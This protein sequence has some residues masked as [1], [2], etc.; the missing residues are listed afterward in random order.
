MT[1][2]YF[3]I[4]LSVIIC[5]HEAGHL[6]TAKMFGVYCYEYAFGMGPTLFKKQ[7]K[8][9]VYSIHAIPIGGFVAMAG[10]TEGDEVYPDVVVPEGRRINDI[11]PWKRIIVM[12]AGVFM[13]FMLAWVIFS[14]IYLSIGAYGRS[15]KPYVESVMENTPAERAGFESGDLVV[16]ISLNDGTSVKPKDF[17]DMQ[18]FLAQYADQELIYVVERNGQNVS[19]P[20][21]PE[22]N[23]E[24][25]SYM[26]G[27]I[28]PD[29][30]IEEV[31]LLNCWRYGAEEMSSIAGL[32]VRTLRQLIRGKGLNQLAGPVG[33]YNATAEY[34]S[35]GFLSFMFLMA[36]LSLNVGI[37][38]L[39]PLPVL[40][41]GQVVLVL[42]EK[43]IG[44]PL[45]HKL[46]AA[47]MGV[48]WVIL[49]SI[50]VFVT[51]NDISR[52]FR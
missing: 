2:I 9:T 16:S 28:G 48:F 1:I 38:N 31:N 23:E 44:K 15:P 24:R 47:I 34:A 35:L 17:T 5:I 46:K 41:G 22:Y 6:I 3:L 42:A 25:D 4:L 8:E 20:V 26:I 12:L 21:T 14:M 33:I 27:I 45:N 37:M 52:L 43:V 18:M 40:D 29:L 30:E 13:N 49:I 7:G 11:K 10:E 19:I 39:L 36:E 32:L 50:M 51:W